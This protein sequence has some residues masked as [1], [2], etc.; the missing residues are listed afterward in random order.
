MDSLE[1][2]PV[3]LVDVDDSVGAAGVDVVVG[4]DD[5]QDG[6]VAAGVGPKQMPRFGVEASDH[7]VAAPGDHCAQF[8][9]GSLF[10]QV[11]IAQDATTA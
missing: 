6:A 9:R 1:E 3:D 5:V 4:R 10:N 2:L 8:I 11:C 7:A